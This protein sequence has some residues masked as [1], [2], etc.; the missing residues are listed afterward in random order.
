MAAEYTND[1][2]LAA[3]PMHALNAAVYLML[4]PENRFSQHVLA[5]RHEE[6]NDHCFS[7]RKQKYGLLEAF[8]YQY[9]TTAVTCSSFCFVDTAGHAASERVSI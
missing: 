6:L 4:E 9:M 1:A 2:G 8:S 3:K 7:I 5:V